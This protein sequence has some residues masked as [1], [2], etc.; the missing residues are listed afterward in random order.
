MKISVGTCVLHRLA[1]REQESHF[2]EQ[3]E[4]DAND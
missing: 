1:C 4:T 2:V 3:V